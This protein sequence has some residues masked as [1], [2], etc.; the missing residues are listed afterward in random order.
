MA[1]FASKFLLRRQQV[2]NDLRAASWTL[3]LLTD[4]P[5]SYTLDYNTAWAESLENNEC[6]FRGYEAAELQNVDVYWD[7]ENN[8]AVLTADELSFSYDSEQAGDD[9]N[10]VTGW[11]L[12]YH[13]SETDTEE[14]VCAG[15]WNPPFQMSGD[16]Q[17]LPVIP[18]LV[19]YQG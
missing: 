12:T 7:S 17:V 2:F 10:H 1:Q 9:D 3:H 8:R 15:P 4:D 19:L 14:F 13:D 5:G 18:L 16:G 11:A 6:T